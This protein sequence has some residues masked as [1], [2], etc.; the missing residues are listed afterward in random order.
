MSRRNLTYL[1]AMVAVAAN[2]GGCGGS[3]GS[4]KDEAPG[5]G[6]EVT[7][8]KAAG[9]VVVQATYDEEMVAL[10]FS[11]KSHQKTSPPGFENVGRIYP[12]Q[13]HDILKWNGTKFDRLPGGTRMDEDRVTFMLEDAARPVAGFGKAGCYVACH[14]N[15]FTEENAREHN[16][17]GFLDHW[18]WRGGRSGPMGM[19]RMPT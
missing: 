16:V 1:L 17:D 2:L 4:P 10:R 18:H 7:L 12:G 3:S 9:D 11:W 19:P 13:F 6:P 5:A 15:M 14:A 8:L